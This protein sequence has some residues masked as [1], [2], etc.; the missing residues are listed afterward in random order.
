MPPAEIGVIFP[1][2]P[3]AFSSRAVL[4]KPSPA[5]DQKHGLLCIG[6]IS[7]SIRVTLPQPPTHLAYQI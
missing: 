7:G 6:S 3:D 4:L 2:T 1:V 5:R